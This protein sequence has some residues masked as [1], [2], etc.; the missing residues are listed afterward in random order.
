MMAS[1]AIITARKGILSLIHIFMPFLGV[2]MVALAV[3]TLVP[4]VVLALP[5]L[6]G[7]KG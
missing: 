2:M 7:Y 6:M 5:R 3:I 1:A 4:D